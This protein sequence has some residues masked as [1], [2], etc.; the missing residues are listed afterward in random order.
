MESSAPP[1]PFLNLEYFFRILYEGFRNGSGSATGFAGI[2]NL[3]SDL[4]LL[5]TVLAY[6]FSL[7]AIG[8]FVYATMRIYQIRQEEEE[9]YST[10]SQHELHEQLE[11][12]RWAYIQQLIESGQEPNWRQAI[13]EADIILDQLL[14]RLG[15]IG[16]S[17][18]EKLKAVNP[19]QFQTLQNAW[20][21]HKV[22]NEIAHQGSA[23]QLSEHLAYRTI[24]QYEAVFRE[25]EEL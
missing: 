21:A 3:L 7:A 25:H 16:D 10:I 12:S 14:T 17:V 2:I 20:E 22:R 6:L 11:S 15:Y 13:I 19:N 1:V 5:V 24:K 4:W 8:V 18:G 9:K 23:F